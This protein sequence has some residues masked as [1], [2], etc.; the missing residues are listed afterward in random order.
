MADEIEPIRTKR[1]YQAAL[2]FDSWQSS[3]TR[4]ANSE[5]TISAARD[6]L[7]PH[8]NARTRTGTTSRHR[9]VSRS[10]PR[11]K[12]PP[13]ARREQRLHLPPKQAQ[14]YPSPARISPPVMANASGLRRADG[15]EMSA[16]S[17]RE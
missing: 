5:P 8:T 3:M 6:R 11:H 13:V 17:P 4:R 15:V 2:G 14:R 16:P 10:Q 7:V 12:R 1:D 9:S